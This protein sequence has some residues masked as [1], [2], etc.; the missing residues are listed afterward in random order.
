MLIFSQEFWLAL[1]LW[2]LWLGKDCG[3]IS[4]VTKVMQQTLHLGKDCGFISSVRKVRQQT[5]WT[6]EGAVEI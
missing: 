6:L 5:N 3:F 1:E 2:T 4:S